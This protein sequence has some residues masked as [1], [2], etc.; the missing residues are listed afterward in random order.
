M[1][2]T[3]ATKIYA[4][5]AIQRDYTLF[6]YMDK[7]RWLNDQLLVGAV[8]DMDVPP[9][10]VISTPYISQNILEPST[11]PADSKIN[12]LVT[13]MKHLLDKECR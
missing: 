3:E 1:Q 7:G 4:V 11:S 2:L 6:D 9:G 13:R 5:P 10:A 8:S 12:A